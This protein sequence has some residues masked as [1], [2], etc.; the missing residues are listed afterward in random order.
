MI[1]SNV[2]KLPM[3]RSHASARV[4]LSCSCEIVCSIHSWERSVWAL[5]IGNYLFSRALMWSPNLNFRVPLGCMVVQVGELLFPVVITHS[6]VDI[7][8]ILV[9][10]RHRRLQDTKWVLHA[11]NIV[12][13]NKFLLALLPLGNWT[14]YPFFRRYHFYPASSSSWSSKP[15]LLELFRNCFF[16]HLLVILFVYLFNW[17]MCSRARFRVLWSQN[18]FLRTKFSR[19]DYS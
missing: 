16:S 6:S 2:S 4:C 18:S 3:R 7:A 8:L 14:A 9:S 13:S 11:S 1:T 17:F 15:S 12:E 19:F 5:R 10:N